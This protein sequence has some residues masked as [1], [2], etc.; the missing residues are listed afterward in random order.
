MVNYVRES[1]KYGGGSGT[2]TLGLIFPVSKSVL[3]SGFVNIRIVPRTS[4]MIVD[5]ITGAEDSPAF[6]FTGASTSAEQQQWLCLGP[7][8]SDYFQTK[9]A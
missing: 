3:V 1:N 7:R 2:P 5:S 8:G 6:V 4:G 9:S